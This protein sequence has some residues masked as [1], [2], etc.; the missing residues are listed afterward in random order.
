[1]AQIDSLISNLN[2]DADFR[3]RIEQDWNSQNSDGSFR[4]DRTRLRY[5][6]RA[7]VTYEAKWYEIGFRVRTGNPR[8]QQ[9]PQ[10]TLGDG[11]KEFGTL[12]MGLEKSYFQGTWNTFSFWI[13]KNTFPF[14][15]SNELFWSDNV[16]PEGVSLD[17]SFIINSAII[18]AFNF[19]GGH[20][21]I[22]TSNKS[23]NQDAYFQGFQIS[24]SFFNKRFVLFPSMY[25][26]KNIPN[27]PDGNDTFSLNYSILHIGT[28]YKVLKNTPLNIEFDYYRNIEDYTTNDSIPATFKGQKSGLVIGLKYGTLKNKGDW[29][30]STNYANL[31]K[32]SAV[33]FLTQNDWARWDYSSSGSPDGRLTNFK[34][35]E[36][37]AGHKIDKKVNLIVKY[38]FVEQ[39]IPF[40]TTRET[41]SRI[42]FDIDV[43]F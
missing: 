5:R 13:G 8:K 33:D 19:T 43:K 35:I 41:G 23:F 29:L 27:I 11:S 34:G 1:S 37:V 12:S 31:E 24:S 6:S 26:F 25:L 9:D 22:A 42:R 2:F 39:I 4:D 40:G 14:E 18:D 30:F 28:K 36:L 7:G 38:Y 21:I 15:K 10:L 3:F 16:Y 17:K 20:Y 32:F